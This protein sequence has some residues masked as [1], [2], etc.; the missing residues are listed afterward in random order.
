M[1]NV[2]SISF[3]ILFISTL[4][5]VTVTSKDNW[6]LSCYPMFSNLTNLS[7]VEIFRLAMETTDGKIV[8]WQSSFPRYQRRIGKILKSIYHLETSDSSS[9]NAS[10][11][12]FQMKRKYLREILRL[13]ELDEEHIDQ[14]Q[15]F[16]VIRRTIEA[17]STR[18]WNIKD[19]L[20]ERIPIKDVQI[21]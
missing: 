17:D 7:D 3:C 16:Q 6:P 21:V 18:N 14:Y 11:Y 1:L 2:F 9:S 20:V 19:D 4:V 15:A 10:N 13:I 5:W 12:S 8:W